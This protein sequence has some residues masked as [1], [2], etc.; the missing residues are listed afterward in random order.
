MGRD[1][2]KDDEAL[3][4]A[5]SI[6]APHVGR[7]KQGTAP[8]QRPWFQSTRPRGARQ[9]LDVAFVGQGSFNPRAHVGRDS[10]CLTA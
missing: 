9:S 7:D 5:V 3:N 2:I 6:H 4:T 10:V 1:L 8:W